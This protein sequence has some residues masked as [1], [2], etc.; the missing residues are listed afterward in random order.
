MIKNYKCI[1]MFVSVICSILLFLGGV[2]L[3]A[4]TQAAEIIQNPYKPPPIEAAHCHIRIDFLS[5]AMGI[6]R[7]LYKKVRDKI[8]QSRM[9]IRATET[10]WGRE[11]E[12]TLCLSFS[13]YQDAQMFYKDLK[14][15]FYEK[16]KGA[17]Q[18]L[19]YTPPQKK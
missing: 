11:G 9:H 12:R 1:K 10:P 4:N 8:T 15:F 18:R 13:S 3:S 7:G 6:D 17:H 5:Y 2:P 14:A 19:I 16:S